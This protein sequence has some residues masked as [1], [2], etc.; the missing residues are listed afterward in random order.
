MNEESQFDFLE[1]EWEALCRMPLENDEWNEG[2]G[3]LNARK[4]LDGTASLEFFE[5]PYGSGWIKGLGL[6][7]FN[8]ESRLW[9]HT[10]TDNANPGY[11]HTW[12]GAFEGGKI[13][14]LAEWKEA[15]G[16]P[17]RS[18]LTWS[19]IE[20]SSAHWESARSHDRGVTWELHWVIDFR[21]I[22]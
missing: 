21:K 4:V 19:R 3:H 20:P 22:R 15:D 11:F 1:G 6:R 8:R 5:G 7:A 12:R 14:L 13:D 9:E 10:W 16:R 18:R 17:I 2:K